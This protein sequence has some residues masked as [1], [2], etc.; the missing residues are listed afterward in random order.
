MFETNSII[1]PLLEHINM[2]LELVEGGE[3]LKSHRYNV[4]DARMII[5]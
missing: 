5:K 4:R 1:F 3:L 2:V